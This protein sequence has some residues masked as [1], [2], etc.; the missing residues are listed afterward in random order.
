MMHLQRF[1]NLQ[2]SAK[3]Q[4]AV[5]IT[6]PSEEDALIKVISTPQED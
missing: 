5:V 1:P 6:L 2:R 3:F 4:A